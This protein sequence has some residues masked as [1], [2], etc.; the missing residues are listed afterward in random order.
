MAT[1]VLF[2]LPVVRQGDQPQAHAGYAACEAASIATPA[3]H[4]M[5]ASAGA[6]VGKLLGLDRSMKGSIGNVSVRMG[7]WVVGALVACNAVNDVIDPSTGQILA[8]GR[9]TDDR[10]L[11]NTQRAFLNGKR[12]NRPLLGTNTV[13]QR[14]TTWHTPT[15]KSLC[16][17]LQS[18]SK[19]LNGRASRT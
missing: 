12:G 16:S 13:L 2:D 5:G 7:P 8:G 18:D 11:A 10:Q 4:N 9:T 6:C 15:G 14:A 1:A 3:P 19:D 17:V